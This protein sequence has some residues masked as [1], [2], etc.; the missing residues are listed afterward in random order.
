MKENKSEQSAGDAVQGSGSV[1]IEMDHVQAY[2]WR[3]LMDRI[4]RHLIRNDCSITTMES[5]TS[6]LLACSV[7]DTEGA[8]AVMKG[9]FIT[10]SNEAKIAQGVPAGIIEQYGV[11]SMETAEAMAAA[12]RTAYRADIGVGVTGTT[13]N[14]DPNNAD[15]VPGE[16]YYVIQ[17]DMKK[18]CCHLTMDPTGLS[19]HEI[20]D[21]IVGQIVCTLADFLEIR[22]REDRW[23]S[24][25]Q[26]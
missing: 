15:S 26:N 9:A 5:C 6:G 4:V 7:T 20:K 12:C 8:S 16:V 19:R 17:K 3:P 13:G 18:C 10:Y 22:E 11:Y 25:K 24:E 21:R 23:K 1:R 14:T 2:D